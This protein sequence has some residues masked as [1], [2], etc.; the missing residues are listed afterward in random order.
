[1]AKSLGRDLQSGPILKNMSKQRFT[2]F[3]FSEKLKD[4]DF[5]NLLRMNQKPSKIKSP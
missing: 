2:M 5:L 4:S 1:M 3:Y